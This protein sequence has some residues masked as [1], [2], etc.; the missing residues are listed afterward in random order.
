MNK[1]YKNLNKW[2]KNMK[3]VNWKIPHQFY[4]SQYKEENTIKYLKETF[5]LI[6]IS[7]ITFN[8]SKNSLPN[9][10]KRNSIII[11]FSMKSI[12]NLLEKIIKENC[13]KSFNKTLISNIFIY[14][15][16]FA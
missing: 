1:K 14:F 13:W 5:L 12:K 7:P 11:S 15:S 2:T 10:I 4:N 9:L 3:S 6:I 8:L 16:M